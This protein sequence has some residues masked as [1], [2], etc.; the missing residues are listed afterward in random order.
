MQFGE[1]RYNNSQRYENVEELKIIEIIQRQSVIYITFRT[2]N[3]K[4][5]G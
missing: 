3:T 2:S 1:A 5:S 4:A